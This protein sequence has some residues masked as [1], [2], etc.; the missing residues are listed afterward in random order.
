MGI[1]CT[2]VKFHELFVL[3]VYYYY[4]S[5]ENYQNAIKFIKYSTVD[6]KPQIG[7]QDQ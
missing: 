4:F 6:Q 3:F 2:S 5:I 7:Y 1:Y